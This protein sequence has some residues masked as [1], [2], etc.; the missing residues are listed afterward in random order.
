MRILPKFIQFL[1]LAILFSSCSNDDD[2]PGQNQDFVVA[3]EHPSTQLN[4]EESSQEIKLVFS[5][6]AP[7]NGS[8]KLALDENQISYDNDYATQPE[9]ANHELIL[10]INQGEEE[11][12]FSIE[13]L[14]DFY[15]KGSSLEVS[16]A[17]VNFSNGI[18]AGNTSTTINFT[19][20]IA[21]GGGINADVGGPNQPNQVF[22]DLSQQNQEASPRDAWDLGFYSGTENR[23]IMNYS[24]Q[25]AVAEL[26]GNDL[27]N[28]T[29]A[30]VQ[31]LQNEVQVGTFNP[32][33]MEYVD[34]PS[35]DLS[36][37][38]IREIN[39]DD[40]ENK[41]YLVNL[42]YRVP[43][44]EPQT[45]SID[46]AGEHKGWKKIRILKSDEAYILRYADLNDTDYQEVNI[47]KNSAYNFSF[48]SF[49]IQS[50]VM[51]EP[52]K[53]AWDLNFTVFTNE[54]P[55]NGSYTYADFILT[56]RH[57]GTRAYQVLTEEYA[58]NNFNQV[59]VDYNKFDNDQR[60][61][62]SEWRSGGGPDQ[63]PSLKEDR[64]Y[65]IEDTEGNLYKLRFTQLVDETGARG[66]PGFE[67]HLLD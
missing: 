15:E 43:T 48:F 49:E 52:Q 56:N 57:G 45:G 64:F 6:A 65:V 22:V 21:S 20:S 26:A 39:L 47:A 13:Q 29:E 35:G 62:G 11:T 61:I 38:S 1:V 55:G 4:A 28:F 23:V 66:F 33:N 14:S 37:T 8:I 40:A 51:V 12:A 50:E 44:N 3:F 67:Y 32:A 42:G 41:V 58:Y 59:D 24:T 36:N 31:A 25:M 10:D 46:I 54:I 34:D 2:S 7:E 19:E 9:A 60:N 5:F 17:E 18:A 63:G 53:S 16:I 30:D 27:S